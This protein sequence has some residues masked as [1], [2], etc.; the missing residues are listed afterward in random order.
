MDRWK[1]RGMAGREEGNEGGRGGRKN[2]GE[3]EGGK[4]KT[5]G[6]KDIGVDIDTDINMCVLMN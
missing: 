2:K 4:K 5:N 6:D 1:D 3:M